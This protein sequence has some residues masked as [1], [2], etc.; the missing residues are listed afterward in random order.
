MGFFDL[1]DNAFENQ[2]DTT[3]AFAKKGLTGNTEQ[4]IN[5]LKATVKTLLDYQGLDWVGRGE[6]FLAN[7]SAS[8][9]A[10]EVLIQELVSAKSHSSL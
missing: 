7:N 10:T 3:Y 9:A 6:L 2:F 4:D 8:I 1:Y 5:T